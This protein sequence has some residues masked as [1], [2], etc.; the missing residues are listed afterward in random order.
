MAA[1]E[2]SL[3]GYSGAVANGLL[4]NYLPLVYPYTRAALN[5][6]ED[7]GQVEAAIEES[8]QDYPEAYI[9][10]AVAGTAAS[11]FGP[12]AYLKL[13]GKALSG[14]A[15]GSKITNALRGSSVLGKFGEKSAKALEV[16]PQVAE[17]LLATAAPFL[18]KPEDEAIG[19]F[20]LSKRTEMVTNPIN[21]ALGAFGTGASALASRAERQAFD[22]LKAGAKANKLARKVDPSSPI[23]ENTVGRKMLD[24]GYWKGVPRKLLDKARDEVDVLGEDVGSLV[25]DASDVATRSGLTIN[26]KNIIDYL[27]N[28]K[29]RLFGGAELT[30]EARD[31]IKIFDSEID[32]IKNADPKTLK[33]WWKEKSAADNA[34]DKTSVYSRYS[35]ALSRGV[36]S[37]LDNLTE[38]LSKRSQAGLLKTPDI[39]QYKMSSATQEAPY[40]QNL[41]LLLG[42]G[43]KNMPATVNRSVSPLVEGAVESLGASD[44]VI[45]MVKGTKPGTPLSFD[46]GK[47]KDTAGKYSTMKVIE[48]A[49]ENNVAKSINPQRKVGLLDTI[50]GG[51]TGDFTYGL[52][53]NKAAYVAKGIDTLAKGAANSKVG[54]ALLA[55]EG[56]REIPQS[57]AAPEEQNSSG[58]MPGDIETDDDG[59]RFKFKGGDPEDQNNWEKY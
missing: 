11:M 36:R 8:Y 9:P 50:V 6:F 32:R 45:N 30:A 22:T 13:A 44:D 28:E 19:D 3:M 46:A 21:L 56:D 24:G 40:L 43:N 18:R 54:N 33:Q 37:E 4:N 12:G 14:A 38:E 51:L 57:I 34:F 42:M 52:R 16:S 58:Y 17:S 29:A 1:K 41:D 7:I 39:P 2:K 55:A 53:N 47:Y 48:K 10:A 26:R 23:S 25:D 49:L 20:D 15:K 35:K 59:N 5:P 31:G 27:Q